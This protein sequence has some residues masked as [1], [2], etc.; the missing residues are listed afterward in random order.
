[1][2]QDASLYFHRFTALIAATLNSGAP[3]TTFMS[4]KTPDLSIRTCTRTVLFVDASGGPDV[5]L[6]ASHGAPATTFPGNITSVPKASKNLSAKQGVIFLAC[7]IS[8]LSL[9]K[10][11]YFHILM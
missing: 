4:R 6:T 5:G 8:L 3:L 1:V 7:L 9:P 2:A 10:S 11:M